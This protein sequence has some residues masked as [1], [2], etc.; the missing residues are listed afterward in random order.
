MQVVCKVIRPS[1]G[2]KMEV[3]IPEDIAQESSEANDPTIM[4]QYIG[5]EFNWDFLP[6]QFIFTTDLPD[7]SVEN[8]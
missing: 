6:L 4:V 2:T 7:I 5:E 3:V 8:E 1:T